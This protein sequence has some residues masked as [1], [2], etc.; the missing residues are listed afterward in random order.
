MKE[1]L[2]KTYLLI[3]ALAA[4][5]ILFIGVRFQPRKA[6]AEPVSPTE[7]ASLQE[8][9]RRDQAAGIGQ[10][11]AGRAAELAD[12]AVFLPDRKT[13]GVRYKAPTKI[14]TPGDPTPLVE[15]VLILAETSKAAL[16]AAVPRSQRNPDSWILIIGRSA[17]DRP[18]WAASI[19]GTIHPSVC[20]GVS[21]QE[22]I[23]NIAL[24]QSFAGAGAYD[25]DGGL[26]G[27]VMPCDGSLHI[28]SIGSV[29]DLLAVSSGLDRQFVE[30]FGFRAAAIPN[31][32]Q[33]LYPRLEGLLITDVWGGGWAE[34][35]GLLP[36]DLI[37]DVLQTLTVTN[38]PA[39]LRIARLGR[40]GVM[41]T[42]VDPAASNK[43]ISVL[44]A[45]DCLPQLSITP[46]TPA[47]QA[48]LRNGDRLVSILGQRDSSLPVLSKLLAARGPYPIGIVYQRGRRRSLVGVPH[49]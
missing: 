25:L 41:R 19:H 2:S 23:L 17:Q 47:E 48:G 35:Q 7:T 18:L 44:P 34:R 31:Q 4:A 28:V 14:L 30:R 42:K 26:L 16:P 8:R 21:Y 38:M 36:G 10:Y 37:V 20:D 32:W 39:E 27:I 13:S 29:P 24:D 49:E 11:L 3:L 1:T 45:F 40:P 33:A 12:Q 15:P 9:V 43:S 22:L 46:G 6:E 5:S